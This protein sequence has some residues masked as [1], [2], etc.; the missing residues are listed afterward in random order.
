MHCAVLALRGS[1]LFFFFH[2]TT[3]TNALHSHKRSSTDGT[4]PLC[5]ISLTLSHKWSSFSIPVDVFQEQT[6][7]QR[8]QKTS[9]GRSIIQYYWARFITNCNYRR[10]W[11]FG[12]NWCGNH[13]ESN[14]IRT[15]ES[16]FW[17]LNNIPYNPYIMFAQKT[18]LLNI[19]ILKFMVKLTNMMQNLVV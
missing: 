8:K 14:S 12:W 5:F 7:K 10:T 15:N 17:F 9:E 11:C 18:T 6:R 19:F 13:F 1:L 2:I 3:H 16:S 4:K